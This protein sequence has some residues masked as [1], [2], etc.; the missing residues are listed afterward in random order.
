PK[1]MGLMC[2]WQLWHGSPIVRISSD[3]RLVSPS[4]GSGGGTESTKDLSGVGISMQ[5]KFLSTHLARR[6][7]DVFSVDDVAVRKLAWVGMPPRLMP[8]V[9]T[10]R[11]WAP[12]TPGMP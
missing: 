1:P 6:T 9:A 10:L 12:V 2:W 4:P 3:C 7:S 5:S 11:I 8:V